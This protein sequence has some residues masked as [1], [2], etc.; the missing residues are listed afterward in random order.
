MPPN[1]WF[2]FY[3]G[4]YLRDL[5]IMELTACERSCW[6]TLLSLA[7][8]EEV[9]GVVKMLKVERL[10][11]MAGIARDKDEWDETLGV[12]NKFRDLD[13]ITLSD[14]G[15]ITVKN[16]TKRQDLALTPYE[17]VK[18]HRMKLNDNDVITHDNDDNESD[19]ARG[20]KIREEEN[21][22]DIY[23]YNVE[24]KKLAELLYSLITEKNPAWHLKPKWDTWADDVRKI[25][26]LDKRTPRQIEA[27]IK[28]AQQDSFWSGNILSPAKL[29]KQFN[30]LVVQMGNKVRSSRPKMSL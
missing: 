28:W 22:L 4:E 2:K 27:V 13:M 25:R 18:K 10:L 29:R 8:V 26:E 16:F 9:P 14:N 24:D 19:N 23:K 3:G 6:V 11:Q 12:L 21:R 20:E 7:S 5:K 30:T 15:L 1:Q 17:R